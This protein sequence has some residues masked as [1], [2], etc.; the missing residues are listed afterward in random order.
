MTF[1]AAYLQ[2]FPPELSEGGSKQDYNQWW[3]QLNEGDDNNSLSDA[4]VISLFETLGFSVD[5]FEAIVFLCLLSG[6]SLQGIEK[7]SFISLCENF[8]CESMDDLKTLVS[9]VQ[10]QLLTISDIYQAFCRCVGQYIIH[11]GQIHFNP[12]VAMTVAYFTLI[13]VAGGK[14]KLAKKWL[15]FVHQKMVEDDPPVLDLKEWNTL[16]DL[17]WQSNETEWTKQQVA[18]W[19]EEHQQF[20][21]GPLDAFVDG[22]DDVPEDFTASEEE[23]RGFTSAELDILR[24]F[25]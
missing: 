17:L 6:E 7:E 20:E 24:A 10:G 15:L 22:F 18:N 14:F 21:G 1:R 23:V 3:V 5:G 25:G 8:Q 13:F 11:E 2:H 9:T 19:Y 4:G 12:E 16:A